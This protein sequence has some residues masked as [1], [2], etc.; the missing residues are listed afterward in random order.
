[1]DRSSLRP[2]AC[3]RRGLRIGN[4]MHAHRVIPSLGGRKPA[5]FAGRSLLN[6]G[7]IRGTLIA[8]CRTV[9]S[10][11]RATAGRDGPSWLRFA[12]VAG[13]GAPFEATGAVWQTMV[14]STRI[15]PSAQVHQSRGPTP[16][17]A[18]TNGLGEGN[19]TADC[20][21]SLL[22]GLR[23]GRRSARSSALRRPP[24]RASLS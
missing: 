16:G 8:L 13:T 11:A 20:P 9:R 1:M 18:R 23:P 5:Q 12:P 15:R 6:P 14:G 21:A 22:R 10:C 3:V 17:V 24:S 4:H 19:H 7:G 2:F